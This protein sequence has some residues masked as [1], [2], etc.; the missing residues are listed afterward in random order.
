[1]HLN[2]EALVLA[3][4]CADVEESEAK[5]ATGKG[6]VVV[7]KLKWEKKVEFKWVQIV[8][9]VA[10]VGAKE[11][12]ADVVCFNIGWYCEI[13]IGAVCKKR[14]RCCYFWGTTKLKSSMR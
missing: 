4:A 5:C 10:A 8:E 14:R 1:M 7:V 13:A 2:Q 9:G 12:E 11:L 3:V 6:L